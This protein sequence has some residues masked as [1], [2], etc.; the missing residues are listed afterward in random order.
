MVS[1]ARPPRPTH[2]EITDTVAETIFRWIESMLPRGLAGVV[3][4]Y[5]REET[6]PGEARAIEELEHRY[7]LGDHELVGAYVADLE[8]LVAEQRRSE[9]HAGNF[10]A[11]LEEPIDLLRRVPPGLRA[12]AF[13]DVLPE[14][15]LLTALELRG[16]L[17]L[18]EAQA[19][20][21]LRATNSLF[22]YLEKVF[23]N[24][25]LPY[26]A[27]DLEGICWVGAASVRD[28]AVTPALDAL[29]D[30]RLAP[31]RREFE[32]AR[33]DF[34]RGDYRDAGKA[35]G[36]AVETAMSVVVDSHGLPHPQTEHGNDLVQAGKLFDVL[37]GS[38]VRLLDQDR[39]HDLIFAAI[40]VR[41][42]CGHGIGAHPQPVDR[43][44]VEAAIG[45]AAVAITY[46][47]SKLP[48][49]S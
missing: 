2:V 36:D 40:K 21:K 17:H 18:R 43:H 38:G 3:D 23:S 45:A 48:D 20:R 27:S 19:A 14:P 24:Y 35:A 28:A 42:T 6:Y 29:A 25:G 49:E 46:L 13:L 30:G 26:T 32:K 5:L 12:R 7:G 31:A 10:G 8:K 33:V 39:D 4:G 16:A 1:I 41:H 22:P 37:K 44:L 15:E 34:R 11:D 9:S 47:A